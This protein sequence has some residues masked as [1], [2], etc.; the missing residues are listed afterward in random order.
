MAE[1]CDFITM[2]FSNTKGAFDWSIFWSAI[3]VIATFIVASGAVIASLLTLRHH[4]KTWQK[5]MSRELTL[6]REHE[7]YKIR[8]DV[9]F[10][11]LDFLDDYTATA[12][13]TKGKD[14]VVA[15]KSPED[16][17]KDGRDCYNGLLLVCNNDELLNAFLK[18]IFPN[19]FSD[20][21]ITLVEYR[22]LCRKELELPEISFDEVKK[23]DIALIGK[24]NPHEEG[25]DPSPE[26]QNGR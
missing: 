15:Y 3:S 10:K 18:L 20:S 13:K 9:I 6:K 26:A 16:F 19:K 25:V 17:T 12:F 7:L 23:K 4:M 11:S 8:K 21:K 24:V 2:F 22:T 1:M 5:E 14:V